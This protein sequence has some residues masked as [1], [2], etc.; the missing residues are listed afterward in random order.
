MDT[1][2]NVRRLAIR[3]RHDPVIVPRA[4]VVVETMCA[5]TVLDA[6]LLNLSARAE[7]VIGFYRK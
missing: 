3:G 6:M 4:A 7:N 2:G 5:L 1:D